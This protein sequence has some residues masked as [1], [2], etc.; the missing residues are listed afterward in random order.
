MRVPL[1]VSVVVPVYNPGANLVP[2]LRAL[3]GQTLPHDRYEIVLVDDGS[4]DG[5]A[6]VL[7]D[8]AHTHPTLIR[9]LHEPNSGWPGRPRNEGV[10][11]ALGDYVQFVD[12]DDLLAPRALE[13]MLA[14]ARDCDADVVLGKMSSDFRGINHEVYRDNQLGVTLATFPLVESLTPHKM[15]RRDFLVHH[16]LRFAEGPLHLE[17]Q[18]FCMNAYVRASSVAVVGDEQCYFYKRRSGFGRNAG[19]I[20]ADPD[21]YYRDLERVLDVIDVHVTPAQRPRLY[22]R[23]YRVEMLGRLRDRQMLEYADDYRRHLFNRVRRLAEERIPR[24][25]DGLLPHFPQRQAALLRARDLPGMLDL[26]REITALRAH[27]DA[28]ALRWVDGRLEVDLAATLTAPV[29]TRVEADVVL[30]SRVDSS[31]WFVGAT[32]RFSGRDELQATVTVDPAQALSGRPLEPGLW[33]LRLRVRA[34]GVTRTT[35]LGQDREGDP[36]R[37]C[38]YDGPP[39]TVAPYRTAA[40]GL[41]LDA[42]EWA[43]SLTEQVVTGAQRDGAGVRVPTVVAATSTRR[44]ADVLVG[45]VRTATH[46]VAGPDGAQLPGVPTEGDAWV[47]VGPPGTSAPVRLSPRS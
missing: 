12:N 8:W 19:D 23:F 39:H 3:V 40:G 6:D 35:R 7:D 20:A 29:D 34:G 16:G 1:D 45:G 41:A 38:L 30:V 17:D 5:T 31:T 42:G 36:L 15:F 33:D 43:H 4:T 18:L 37:T 22:E 44:P 27:A 13:R 2:C 24:S 46:L 28:R 26:A 25:V 11:T 10:A 14:A 21:D 32:Q 9:V 47:R